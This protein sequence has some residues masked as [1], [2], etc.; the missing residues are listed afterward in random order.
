MPRARVIPILL[1]KGN[2]LVKTKRFRDPVYVGDPIN[3]IRIF[4]EKEVDELV[5]LDIDATPHDRPPRLDLLRTLTGECF[6]PLCY[7][8]GIRAVATIEQVLRLGVEKVA[9]NTALFEAPDMVRGAVSV[10]GSSTIV[11]SIDFRRGVFGQATAWVRSGQRNTRVPIVDAAR[12][13]EDLGVG[14]IL[15]SSIERDGTMSGYDLDLIRS[16]SAAVRIPVIANGGAGSHSDLRE[17]LTSGGASAAA[18]GALFVFVGKHR[19]VLITYPD[20]DSLRRDV[21]V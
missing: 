4:N 2:G 10:Y 17:V 8:G 7:G 1:I 11:G 3:A 12:R 6:M 18:A 19:A 16:V 21:Y 13:A 5:V 15:L 20:Q 14:E 9:I